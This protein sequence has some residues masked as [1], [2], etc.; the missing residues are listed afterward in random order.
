MAQNG[1]VARVRPITGSA[2]DVSGEGE[3]EGDG[4]ADAAKTAALAKSTNAPVAPTKPRTTPIELL[5]RTR[6]GFLELR[7]MIL[8]DLDGRGVTV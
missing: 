8:G 1:V 5:L 7:S 3:G 2:G 4:S 6:A